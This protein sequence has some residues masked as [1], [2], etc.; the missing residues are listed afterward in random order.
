[1][2]IKNFTITRS[3][4]NNKTLDEIQVIKGTN[5]TLTIIVN[6][7]NGNQIQ[8]K[9][10]ICIKFN[11]KTFIHANITNGIINVTLPTDTFKNTYNMT[12]ILGINRL[13]NKATYNGTIK[14]VQPQEI[15]ENKN[16]TD[17]MTITP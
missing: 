14:I 1:M 13:Y 17:N 2:C 6:D 15:Y 7:T 8:G 3:D 9:T 4:I 10:P 11:G 5:T 12:I 16:E